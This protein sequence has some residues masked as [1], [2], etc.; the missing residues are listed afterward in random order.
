MQLIYSVLLP[1]LFTIYSCASTK[2][3]SNCDKCSVQIAV[4]AINEN[5]INEQIIEEL[6]CTGEDSCQENSEFMEV[7]NEALFACLKKSPELFVKQISI[8]SK[9]GFILKQ[10]ES[11]INDNIN[12]QEIIDKLSKTPH[13]IHTDSYTKILQALNLAKKKMQ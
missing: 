5:D 1:I 6:F 11:P 8:S 7:F 13:E 3:V 9:Q 12:P 10:L 2:A 4:M